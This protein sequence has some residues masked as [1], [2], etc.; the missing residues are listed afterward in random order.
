MQYPDPG[1]QSGGDEIISSRSAVIFNIFWID[2]MLQL[3]RATCEIFESYS[4]S[5]MSVS[6]VLSESMV[7]GL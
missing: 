2:P 7:S 1:L 5:L 6:T 3:F 4:T